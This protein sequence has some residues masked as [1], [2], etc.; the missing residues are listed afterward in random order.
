MKRLVLIGFAAYAFAAMPSFSVLAMPMAPAAQL[1]AETDSSVIL[2]KGG[3]GHGWGRAFGRPFGWS[4]GRKVG[5]QDGDEGHF[6]VRILA[7]LGRELLK[8]IG[9]GE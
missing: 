8:P 1:I 7:T 2:A 3:H 4:R 9:I 6:V 5:W